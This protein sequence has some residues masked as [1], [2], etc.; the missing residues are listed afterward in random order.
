MSRILAVTWDGG[1]NVPPLLGITTAL[2]ERDHQVRVLGH[3][4]QR[5]AVESSGAEFVAYQHARPWSSDQPASNA[6]WARSLLAMF[7]ETTPALDV[8]AQLDG[9]SAPD[10]VLVDAMRLVALRAAVRSSIPTVALMH[11]FHHYFT[12]TWARGPVGMLAS[13]R[14]LR[15]TPL[16]NACDRVLVATDPDLD[17]ATDKPLPPNVRHIGAV[18]PR[19]RPPDRH[20][21]PLVL[22]SLSTIFYAKQRAVLQNILDGL[23]QLDVRVIAATGPC[24]DPTELR[25]GPNVELHRH[26]DH[27]AAMATASLLVGHGGHATTLRAL[28]HDL[29][30]LVLPLDPHLDHT[31][32]GEA[33]QAAGAG[34]L[35]PTG[36]PPATIRDAAR[37]LLA[38]GPH[39][40]A[41][42]NLGARIRA[43]D[44]AATAV[45]EIETLLQP[46]SN[47]VTPTSSTDSNRP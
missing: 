8:A 39:Q 35:L 41:A 23:A 30:L 32:I 27:T 6:R 34:R 15:P 37:D 25:T 1:G 29:P 17:P 3:P 24:V 21:T 33:V 38:E 45:N 12:P 7:T 18:Q 40:R 26:L 46:H 16:W 42:A 9:P 19:P 14:G 28:A 43:R 5:S 44:G 36:A 20:G 10:L 22:V 31:M 11:S 47:A 2:R 13:L 4:Q